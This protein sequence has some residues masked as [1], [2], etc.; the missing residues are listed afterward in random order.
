M[1]NIQ[2]VRLDPGI[3]RALTDHPEYMEALIQDDWPRVADL[4]HR[5]IGRTLVATPV[6]ID[7]LQ[8]GGYFVVDEHTR[9][10]VGSCAFKTPPTEDGTVEIAYFTYPGFEG[11]GYATGMARKLIDLASGSPQVRQVIAHTLPATNASTRILE[12]VG[13]TLIGEVHDPA[14]GRVWRWQIFTTEVT[15]DLGKN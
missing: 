8:W 13:M 11:R 2:L 10:V 3:E 12:R 6:S 14:D 7:E 4:V 1:A 5:L 9:E 15:E